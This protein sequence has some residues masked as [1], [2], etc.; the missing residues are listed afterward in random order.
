MK[1]AS[2]LTGKQEKNYGET[3]QKLKMMEINNTSKTWQRKMTGKTD[4]KTK[5][6]LW[7]ELK[8]N[9]RDWEKN[10]NLL[11][12]HEK[13]WQKNESTTL[14]KTLRLKLTIYSYSCF[15]MIS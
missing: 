5:A 2:I 1:A 3:K 13:N 7:N 9:K 12:K 6:K 11:N 15:Y 10:Y 8:N 4:R 14:E